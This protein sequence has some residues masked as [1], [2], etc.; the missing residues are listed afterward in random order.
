MTVSSHLTSP[1][2]VLLLYASDMVFNFDKPEFKIFEKVRAKRKVMAL[3]YKIGKAGQV[4]WSKG[5]DRYLFLSSALREGFF[6]KTGIKRTKTNFLAPAVELAPFLKVKPDYNKKLT[7]ARHSSQGNK[8]FSEDL[9]DIMSQC[10]AVFRFLPGPSWLEPAVNVCNFLYHNDPDIVAEFLSKA[11]MF[12]YLLPD[13]YTDQGPRVIV[14][15]MAAG[16]PVLAE[17]RDGP[18][19][20]V[21]SETGWK[22]DSHSEAIDIINSVTAEELATKGA[23][24]RAR[25]M[26]EFQKEQW[27]YE[28]T[29]K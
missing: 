25:A 24:A 12:W 6:E 16:L 22:I 18:A 3:T 23:A 20:R 1:C 29:G 19:D 28:I 8:K 7:V 26:K 4:P 5:W 10:K 2:D 9:P 17:N 13:G 27:Y 14:E 21:T 15:A 11:N